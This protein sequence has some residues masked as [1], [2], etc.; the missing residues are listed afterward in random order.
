MGGVIP[1][2]FIICYYNG[3]T[4]SPGGGF[5]VLFREIHKNNID[6]CFQVYCVYTLGSNVQT[7]ARMLVLTNN[8]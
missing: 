1:H 2:A 6:R 7:V 4:L 3:L 5:A 8:C